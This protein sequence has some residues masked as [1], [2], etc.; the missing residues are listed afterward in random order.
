MKLF[1]QNMVSLRC[2]MLVKQELEKLHL[3]Y[4][5]LELG[6]IHLTK[7]IS[8]ADKHTLQ[9]ALHEAGLEIMDDKKS[10]IIERIKNVIVE[11][12]HYADEMPKEKYSAYI[13]EKVGKDYH[14]LSELFSRNKGITIE[15][16]IILHKIE[17]AKELMMYDEL[18]ISEIAYKL[19]YSS[20][21]H[22]SHQFKKV[23]GLTPTFFKQL[24]R[25]KRRN[26]EDI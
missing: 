25:K 5:Y 13:S 20:V 4:T 23:T 17:R 18:T 1:I 14:F 2:K 11:M 12:I 22:L 21:A 15:H 16:F 26:L 8:D 10:I 9:A 19:N 6:E 3:H 7:Y 24:N